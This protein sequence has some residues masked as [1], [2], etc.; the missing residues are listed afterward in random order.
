MQNTPLHIS[1]KSE[2]LKNVKAL[3]YAGTNPNLQDAEGKTALHYAAMNGGDNT[4][5]ALLAAGADP[6]I[7]DDAGN[8]YE[9]YLP[10]ENED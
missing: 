1:A 4:I 10:R 9:A 7:R 6:T 8:T 2:K 3:L 5:Q